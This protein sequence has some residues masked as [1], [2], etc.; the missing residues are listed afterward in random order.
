MDCV[1]ESILEWLVTAV[2]LEWILK[3]AIFMVIIRCCYQI[4]GYLLIVFFIV[5]LLI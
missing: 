3:I 5:W 1:M 4:L 2:D